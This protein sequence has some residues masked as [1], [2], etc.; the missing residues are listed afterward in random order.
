MQ[1]TIRNVPPYLDEALR[2]RAREE[3]K[4]LNEVTVEALLKG[5]ALTGK[6]IRHRDLSDVAGTWTGEP[7][8][9]EV[10]QDQR[11]IDPDLWR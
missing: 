1:Y 10:L 4:S 9:E 8:I 6:T 2:E 11:H 7:E 5:L 3:G